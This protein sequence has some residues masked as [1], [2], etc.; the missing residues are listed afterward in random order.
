M[1]NC[2]LFYCSKPYKQF[3]FIEGKTKRFPLAI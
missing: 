2:Q 1:L 3:E